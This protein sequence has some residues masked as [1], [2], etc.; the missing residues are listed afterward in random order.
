MATGGRRP[1]GRCGKLFEHWRIR[2]AS[3]AT[4]TQVADTCKL[5]AGHDGDHIG[6][7]TGVHWTK[8]AQKR[9]MIT[10]TGDN[11]EGRAEHFPTRWA[12]EGTM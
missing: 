3:G 7:W 2:N 9:D 1:I 12:S 8:N 6:A 11:P 10:N 5:P 4:E